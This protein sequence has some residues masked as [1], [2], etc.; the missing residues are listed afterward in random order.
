MNRRFYTVI[1]SLFLG[2]LTNTTVSPNGNDLVAGLYKVP[3]GLKTNLMDVFSGYTSAVG[4]NPVL[5]ILYAYAAYDA[6]EAY[7]V[8]C[9]P[10]P[11][12]AIQAITI[13]NTTKITDGGLWEDATS[14]MKSCLAN[15]GIYIHKSVNAPIGVATKLVAPT[16]FP[17]LAHQ[18]DSSGKV[19]LLGTVPFGTTT[20]SGPAVFTLNPTAAFL[21]SSYTDSRP[22]G[23][24]YIESLGAQTTGSVPTT[25]GNVAVKSSREVQKS[26]GIIYRD[27]AGIHFRRFEGWQNVALPMINAV[28]TNAA[29]GNDDAKGCISDGML[30]AH[31][32]EETGRGLVSFTID[33]TTAFKIIATDRFGWGNTFRDATNNL[34]VPGILTP[35]ARLGT[36]IFVMPK[37][38]STVGNESARITSPFGAATSLDLFCCHID[39]AKSYIHPSKE[40]FPLAYD[41]YET[42]NTG[43]GEKLSKGQP[44]TGTVSW[45]KGNSSRPHDCRTPSTSITYTS[46]AY[47][48]FNENNSLQTLSA[49]PQQ[50]LITNLNTSRNLWFAFDKTPSGV[51]F[52]VGTGTPQNESQLTDPTTCPISETVTAAL[53]TPYFRNFGFHTLGTARRITNIQSSY[54]NP[55]QKFCTPPYLNGQFLFW[56]NE[57]TLPGFSAQTTLQQIQQATQQLASMGFSIQFKAKGDNIQVALGTK[58]ATLRNSNNSPFDTSFNYAVVAS[59][60]GVAMYKSDGKTQSQ[61]IPLG[62]GTAAATTGLTPLSVIQT[63]GQSALGSTSNEA[64][65]DYWITF[66]GGA[67][68]FGQGT[69]PG[70]NVIASALD[71][72]FAANPVINTTFCLSSYI[73]STDYI[74][75]SSAAYTPQAY[76]AQA[77]GSAAG[78]FSWAATQQ[79]TTPGSGSLVFTYSDT[80]PTADPNTGVAT[81]PTITIGLKAALPQAGTT[82]S[83]PDYQVILGTQS[84]AG[85]SML[86][87][88]NVTRTG[89]STAVTGDGDLMPVITA[90]GTTRS[91]WLAYNQGVMAIGF[92]NVV[93]SNL[94]GISQSA[95]I[96]GDA[97]RYFAFTSSSK[98]MQ[99]KC[100]AAKLVSRTDY[101][102]A[103]GTGT[104]LH[105]LW[106]VDSPNTCALTF[107]AATVAP[108]AGAGGQGTP[109]T[110]P[111]II[112]VG[113]TSANRDPSTG[114]V[115]TVTI[116]DNG[117]AYVSKEGVKQTGSMVSLAPAQLASTAAQAYWVAFRNGAII[118]GIGNNP[119]APGA[120]ILS[121]QDASFNAS[122]APITAFTLGG[123]GQT[124]NYSNVGSVAFDPYSTVMAAAASAAQDTAAIQANWA[125]DCTQL[126]LK[127]SLSQ[128]I[129]W[130]QR[131]TFA[132]NGSTSLTF[133]VQKQGLTPLKLYLGLTNILTVQQGSTALSSV[134][135]Y[136]TFD[137]AGNAAIVDN[138]T[139]AATKLRLF[140][141][142]GAPLTDAQGAFTGS[143]S[144]AGLRKLADGAVHNV[145]VNVLTNADNSI[146]IALGLNTVTGVNPLFTGTITPPVT[147]I[148]FNFFGFG[149]DSCSAALSNIAAAAYS[150]PTSSSTTNSGLYNW[151]SSWTFGTPDREQ[152]SFKVA[153]QGGSQVIFGIGLGVATATA[154]SQQFGGSS[155]TVTVDSTGEIGL[156]KAPD[157]STK[158]GRLRYADQQDSANQTLVTSLLNG[159]T[160]TCTLG[161]DNGRFRLSIDGTS[162]WT[163]T[164]PT[165]TAGIARFSF[166]TLQ[167][168]SRLTNIATLGGQSLVNM[169]Q[170]F[171]P[172]TTMLATAPATAIS[173][174]QTVVN[175]QLY[176]GNIDYFANNVVRVLLSNAELFSDTDRTTIATLINSV[177]YAP[178]SVFATSR[179][180]PPVTA[181]VLASFA[182]TMRT[183]IN[184]ATILSIYNTQINSVLGGTQPLAQT[185]PVRIL[186]FYKLSQLAN[187]PA[188]TLNTPGVLPAIQMLIRSFPTTPGLLS[189]QEQTVLTALGNLASSN[190]ILSNVQDPSSLLSYIA[191]GNVPDYNQQ[192]A[193]LLALLS[194]RYASLNPQPGVAVQTIPAL[195]ADSV[196]GRTGVATFGQAHTLVT[197]LAVIVDNRDKLS[198]TGMQSLNSA[199]QVANTI[200]E[201]KTLTG[202]VPSSNSTLKLTE[203]MTLAG[204]TPDFHAQVAWFAQS[205]DQNNA[206][207]ILAKQS[208]DQTRQ[209]FFQYLAALPSI[210][211]AKKLSDLQTLNTVIITLQASALSTAEAA[212]VAQV[213]KMISTSAQLSAVLNNVQDPTTLLSTAQGIPDVNMQL[214]AVQALLSARRTALNAQSNGLLVDTGNGSATNMPA[215]TTTQAQ[216]TIDLLASI[217][218]NRDE[219]TAAN[220]KNLNTV[221]QMAQSV[222]ET[223]KLKSTSPQLSLNDLVTLAATSVS[224][225]IQVA[226]LQT[227]HG[228]S[229]ANVLASG[230]NS[231]IR[232]LYFQ[233][234]ASIPTTTNVK[235]ISDLQTLNTIV[236]T[237]QKGALS[238]S[239]STIVTQVSS[240]ITAQSQVSAVLANVQDPTTL[241][242]TAQALPDVNMQFTAAQTLLTARRNA[243]N[244]QQSSGGLLNT[245]TDS[246]AMP[247]LT[248]A[249][250]QAAVGLLASIAANRD[251][252]NS[253]NL[254]A[255]PALL[256]VAQSI[257]ETQNVKV[258]TTQQ[259]LGDL[260]TLAGTAVSF[261]TQ[262]AKLQTFH[263]S[264]IVDIL[265]ASSNSQIR[266]LYFQYLAMIPSTTNTKSISDL[267]ALNT[268]VTTLQSGSLSSAEAAVVAQVATMLTSQSQV[269]T[270]ITN[271]Q[272][273]STLLSTAQTLADFN[274]QLTAVQNLLVA[275]RN[276]INAQQSNNSVL[277]SNGTSNAMP[278]LTNAQAQAA[279]DLLGSVTLNRDELT[280]ANLPLLAQVIQIAQN[281]PETGS[282]SPASTKQSLA[283]LF[284][285]AQA[286]IS[287]TAQVAKFQLF[288][289]STL[290][291]I[292]AMSNANQIRQLYFQYLASVLTSTNTK[293]IADLTTFAKLILTPLQAQVTSGI[294]SAS[295]VAVVTQ[296]VTFV[297]NLL[298]TSSILTNTQDPTALL[299]AAQTQPDVNQQLTAVQTL[300]NAR[301][302]AVN[303]QQQATSNGII[304]GDQTAQTMPALTT[305]QAQAAADLLYTIAINRDELTTPNIS[306]LLQTLQVAQNLP[307]TASLKFTSAPTQTFATVISLV[308]TPV[309][310]T[311]QVAKF[312]KF[313]GATLANILA[314]SNT[315]Q[316]RQLYFQY[317]SAFSSSTTTKMQADL[318]AFAKTV[319][320][321]LQAQIAA[322][323]A[324]TLTQAE[325]SIV[326]EAVNT[327]NNLLQTTSV[328]SNTSDPTALLAAA[329]AV[330]DRNMQLTAVQ[331]LLTAR[332]NA[333]NVTGDTAAI[334]TDSTS[335]TTVPPLTQAQAQMAVDLLGAIT[336]NRDELTADNFKNLIFTLQLAQ[337]LPETQA[338]K[339]SGTA[340]T[341]N[342]LVSL[343]NVPVDFHAQ[344]LKLQ[345]F[346][347]N[348]VAKIIAKS[349][350]DQVRQLFFQYLAIVASSTAPKQ[351]ADLTAITNNVITPLQTVSTQLSDTEGASLAQL[352]GMMS[353]ATQTSASF[354]AQLQNAQ[355]TIASLPDYITFLAST[356]Q[357]KGISCV[358]QQ[359]DYDT[360]MAQL[361]YV[362]D[363]RELIQAAPAGTMSDQTASKNAIN[364]VLALIKAAQLT[365]E[366]A[367]HKTDLTNLAA[368]VIASHNFAERVA[369]AQNEVSQLIQRHQAN[370]SIGTSNSPDYFCNR[371]IAK[372]G[373]I[374]NAPGIATSAQFDTLDAAVISPLLKLLSDPAQLAA[375]Q[376]IRSTINSS[377]DTI[378]QQQAT[379]A[380]QFNAA[381]S[382][383]SNMSMY[384]S[385]LKDI[386][387]NQRLGTLTFDESASGSN[388][389]PHT[390]DSQTYLDTLTDI[391]SNYLDSLSSNDVA[392]LSTALNYALF[393]D[394]YKKS[395]S[396]TSKIQALATM[397][398]APIPFT[399]RVANY[400]S[401]IS[402]IIPGLQSEDPNRVAFF[403]TLQALLTAPGTI[404]DDALNILNT[405]II[406]VLNA[407][408]LNTSEQSVL[409]SLQTFYNATQTSIKTANYQFGVVDAYSDMNQFISGLTDMLAR[410][411][412]YFTFSADDAT[413]FLN[414]VSYVVNSRE[415][416]DTN[417]LNAAQQLVASTLL[418]PE[419]AA[420]A[421][422]INTLA[423]QLSQPFYFNDRVAWMINEAAALVKNQVPSTNVKLGRLIQKLALLPNAPQQN[424]TLQQFNDVQSKVIAPLTKLTLSADQLS[425]IQALTAQLQTAKAQVAANQGTFAYNFAN[426]QTL[427]PNMDAYIAA[428]SAM[429]VQQ[430]KGTLAFSGTDNATLLNEL[431]SLINNRDTLT[432]AQMAAMKSLLTLCAASAVFKSA[433][434]QSTIAG[435]VTTIVTPIPLT[436]LVDK[437]STLVKSVIFLDATDPS[438]VQFF[439]ALGNLAKSTDP[440]TADLLDKINTNLVQPLQNLNLGF[441]EQTSFKALQSFVA[442]ATQ[443]QQS[444]GYLLQLADDMNLSLSDYAKVVCSIMSQK[445]TTLTFNATDDTNALSALA[446]IDSSR[447]LLDASQTKTLQQL[448]SQLV[449]LNNFQAQNQQLQNILSDLGT[450][451]LFADRVS[452]MSQELKTMMAAKTP[453]TGN[454]MK[455]LVTKMQT[456][457]GSQGTATDGDFIV[458]TS[459]LGALQR[460]NLP[461][462]LAQIVANVLAQATASEQQILDAQKT[463]AYNFTQA[464]A[465]AT[466]NNLSG[467]VSALQNMITQMRAGNITFGTGD[468][469]TFLNALLVVGDQRD[470]L[471]TTDLANLKTTINT[472]YY[473]PGFAGNTQYQQAL[474]ALLGTLNTPVVFAQRVAQYAGQVQKIVQLDSSDI[475]RIRFFT[476]IQLLPN[477]SGTT[478]PGDVDNFNTQVL[479]PLQKVPLSQSEQANV[480]SLLSFVTTQQQQ[481]ATLAYNL[482]YITNQ[483]TAAQGDQTKDTIGIMIDGLTSIIGQVNSGSIVLAGNDFQQIVSLVANIVSDKELL[484]TPQIVKMQSLI[485][486]VS[487]NPNFSQFQS[488]LSGLLTSVTT[489]YTFAERVT[490][491]AQAMPQINGTVTTDP[492]KA[493]FIKMVSTIFDAP[494]ARTADLINNY[495]NNVLNPIQ[496][497][498]FTAS[499]KSLATQLT[500]TAE[501]AKATLNTFAY[502]FAQAQLVPATEEYYAA[503]AQI[504]TD[505][506]NA[507]ITMQPADYTTLLAEVDR[508]VGL[509]PLT[510]NTQ[511]ALS[512]LVQ[513]MNTSAAFSARTDLK[514]RLS[515]LATIVGMAVDIA[516]RATYFSQNITSILSKSATDSSGQ[517]TAASGLRTQFFERITLFVADLGALP[518]GTLTQYNTQIQQ[519]ATALTQSSQSAN[520]TQAEVSIMTA[521]AREL[522]DLLATPVVATTATTTTTTGVTNPNQPTIPVGTLLPVTQTTTGRRAPTRSSYAQ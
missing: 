124:L 34:F 122:S 490:K 213:A 460:M 379:F 86:S 161:Y 175:Q 272:D 511:S 186:L 215:L 401:K 111:G 190:A 58:P 291:A 366:L 258:G 41:C 462:D 253:A 430:S 428:F 522:Q 377:R 6:F 96:T 18:M 288:H 450:T 45:L 79:L 183:P 17:K 483:I 113:L 495:E 500:A 454:R 390:P 77:L 374:I 220:S 420:S 271:V 224:F 21:G 236:T 121:W 418:V 409:S 449:W 162:V 238:D 31:Q 196:D 471:S 399:T 231:Q 221:L 60:K 249:Q 372:L 233:Y 59:R 143:N 204:T 66:A 509:R 170:L 89:T 484:T 147:P 78:S 116:G 114:T 262:V 279:V 36:D 165:P 455:R 88:G 228:S 507:V 440:V 171:D 404:T 230:S 57:W 200:P 323:A 19:Q 136:L 73:R 508:L 336:T 504:A 457:V 42:G 69:T 340:S 324:S 331:N 353:G 98:S 338:L 355:T 300:L 251:E 246:S 219:L 194:A 396:A 277:D 76:N 146:T 305:T 150:D 373:V 332:R 109:A 461:S 16:Q 315:A 269:S 362:V 516:S 464:T 444:P 268:I 72:S 131:N 319:L 434:D 293:Q 371:L 364:S 15:G 433:Q 55:A 302:N 503:L 53:L 188:T 153:T 376:T 303:A 62:D 252:L 337:G 38:P 488:D 7:G 478:Q 189:A 254:K 520:A 318:I 2:L 395:P 346:N 290:T 67:L 367:P 178:P 476:N 458:L 469:Q 51:V 134:K 274:M 369:Y 329:Q 264:A 496:Y 304:G 217:T 435:L 46:K 8:P 33:S 481:A 195:T 365:P 239:E 296:L 4:S 164:D 103:P 267:Q 176:A 166:A 311:A 317:L 411:G 101:S 313:H 123:Q 398:A 475:S 43:W 382:Q 54:L 118:A 151:Q 37:L 35:V 285:L 472:T 513:Q 71:N 348:T 177:S 357:G 384:I 83:A 234:L 14:F 477:L 245:G 427:K 70:T 182:Q 23:F 456:V 459:T 28:S 339:T 232:P 388:G 333:M 385:M 446:Y 32:L 92:G 163:Y 106:Q 517:P 275:R 432:S 306:V 263:G 240:M 247:A 510:P 126:T 294:L 160:H 202:K 260:I 56:R 281:L 387:S 322:G 211:N 391:C 499:Q 212:T 287:F 139:G 201:T 210:N 144:I 506:S 93:G 63:D 192:V 473:A 261:S 184:W 209:L 65:C 344:T 342:D 185:D 421:A 286:P 1:L 393:S 141:S 82:A 64:Y 100:T 227:F 10:D 402:S 241:L 132:Q 47:Q 214:T 159:T 39:P 347:G 480:A 312:Q 5:E 518:A 20:L 203:L 223:Q 431:T 193:A 350:T 441:S 351:L 467:Y 94:L 169:Q 276:A 174:L 207:N 244:A 256:R 425:A 152:V 12:G 359:A 502:R 197:L 199:L 24:G 479:V 68:Q 489:P 237:L 255:L 127:S 270:I 95:P 259:S 309:S 389:K 191:A 474:S 172:L 158:L 316:V 13:T 383:K 403:N 225:S 360:F 145:W 400:A 314:M 120:L 345:N 156:F 130:H 99:I 81:P 226:K 466:A 208:T 179:A 155:Y 105:P 142:Q 61:S 282:L 361:E 74:N 292:L 138:S 375:V 91:M 40:L 413:T 84:G 325:T 112:Q 157:F 265:A 405:Q 3:K 465:L 75:I 482:T 135:Y 266:P 22:A 48:Y 102:A 50:P 437:Y 327:A 326:A 423:T 354:T 497:G 448:I 248:T 173:Q 422:A 321:P 167:G 90:D 117:T 9:N 501:A 468:Y 463:F 229:I 148:T 451:H 140:D 181:A 80:A 308:Q 408:P 297:N 424:T 283:N 87:G 44:S 107:S 257:P 410:K 110:T 412:T 128:Q 154:S 198:S 284:T 289:N 352:T 416:L 250:A 358:F 301:S 429:M 115:Y 492:S 133:G 470:A 242:S 125:K 30:Y 494:G 394:L 180:T 85:Y 485:R 330:F 320:T 341:L 25:L 442:S 443:M 149:G 29:L 206:K 439:A 417:G 328:L 397:I 119:A 137:E 222:P 280:S 407:S 168:G 356:I 11:L 438:R 205:I 307:D 406:T 386:I 486:A 310:F 498:N 445:G 415:V 515:Q 419:F 49:A 218:A 512:S 491:Y 278:P 368:E 27:N 378:L 370:P 343:T 426:A 392:A 97:T 414:E 436:K 521:A 298:Q 187:L 381:L 129:F 26:Y 334:T 514:A 216:A 295:E 104:F 52:K 487:Y 299:A 335:Q 108:K 447:E 493:P 363:S 519:C 235:S 349:R 505:I 452:Y 273:P 380:Y 453:V 243:I